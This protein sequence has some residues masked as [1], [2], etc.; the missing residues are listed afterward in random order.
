MLPILYNNA[1][2]PFLM[3]EED[4]DIVADNVNQ[5]LSQYPT[6][7]NIPRKNNNGK[8]KISSLYIYIF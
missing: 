5:A 3:T 1:E 7:R 8:I 2:C 6:K 4:V